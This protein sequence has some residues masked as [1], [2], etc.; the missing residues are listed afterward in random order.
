MLCVN[1]PSTSF[2]FG[3]NHPGNFESAEGGGGSVQSSTGSR[4]VR[5]SGGNAG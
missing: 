2:G 5:I 3:A 1:R 4:G